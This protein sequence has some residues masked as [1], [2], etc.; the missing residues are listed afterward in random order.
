MS[1]E[2]GPD[3][4]PAEAPNV[5][6]SKAGRIVAGLALAAAVAVI[7]WLCGYFT[8]L[9][10]VLFAILIGMALHPLVPQPA[11]RPGL[12]IAAKPLLRLGVALL[13]LQITLG[14]FGALGVEAVLVTL[15]GLFLTLGIGYWASRLIGL[16][17]GHSLVAAGAVAICGASAALA[18][19]AVAPRGQVREEDAAGTV[20]AITV[21]GTI[22]L[23][24]FP[25]LAALLGYGDRVTG[26]FLGATIHEVAQAVAAGL[27]VSDAAGEAA[28][29]TKL[30]RVACLGLIVLAIGAIGRGRA[31]G[32]SRPPL[33]P[34][35]VI[36][37]FLLAALSSTGAVPAEAMAVAREVSR[38]L[39]LLAIAAIGLKVS[40]ARLASTGLRTLL[41][42]SIS[43]VVLTA[44]VIG[45]LWLVSA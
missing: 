32:A 36:A 7:A 6:G 18:I 25:G 5:V 17:V 28:T 45:G 38:A 8:A 43:S 20:A 35:F 42:V 16:T 1:S 31:P 19:A 15:G 4:R 9:P 11:V 24:A 40:L 29:I 13:G 2:A 22:A 33:V 27:S 12:D 10:A 30:L 23:L 3:Y 39:L 37:F 26:I 34:L 44:L 21:V 41:S 14:D